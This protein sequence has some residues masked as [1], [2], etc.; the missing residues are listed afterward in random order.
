MKRTISCLAFAAGGFLLGSIPEDKPY[1]THFH[2]NQWYL[3]T[4]EGSKII[5]LQGEVGTIEERL[6]GLIKEDNE[7][8]RKAYESTRPN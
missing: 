2:E 5:T 1:F 7:E 4:P 6:R 8:L 3:G